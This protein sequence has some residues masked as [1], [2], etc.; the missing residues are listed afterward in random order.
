M[1]IDKH[2]SKKFQFG[3]SSICVGETVIGSQEYERRDRG[4]T[5]RG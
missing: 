1:S 4:N 3:S 5:M 2:L